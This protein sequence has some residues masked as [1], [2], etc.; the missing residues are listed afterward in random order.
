MVRKSLEEKRKERAER[1][2]PSSSKYVGDVSP[3]SIGGETR[4]R[5][6]WTPD[7]VTGKIT[8]PPLEEGKITIAVKGKATP[9]GDVIPTEKTV[10]K[11]TR[12]PE[13]IGMFRGLEETYAPIYT[14]RERA[15]SFVKGLPGIKRVTGALPSLEVTRVPAERKAEKVFG[16]L[17]PGYGITKF[18]V[19]PQVSALKRKE[20]VEGL[21]RKEKAKLIALEF[22]PAATPAVGGAIVRPLA[23]KGLARIIPIKT[24][25]I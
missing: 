22:L 9:P 6:G 23:I 25:T 14:R 20:V 5:K 19:S 4:R 10:V 8:E 18:A 2:D 7:P 16:F 11:V 3:G 17:F 12:P 13:A 15:I 21:T 24:K 1:H